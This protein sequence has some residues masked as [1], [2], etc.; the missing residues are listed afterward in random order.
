M[1][2]CKCCIQPDT[3]PGIYFDKQGICGV[4]LNMD[5]KG[6]MPMELSEIPLL[7]AR[8]KPFGWH[9][10]Y[11]FPGKDLV[12]LETIFLSIETVIKQYNSGKHFSVPSEYLIDDVSQ[13]V[14]NLIIGTAR[15]SNYWDLISKR[16]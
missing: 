5:N 16:E 3:R 13:R 10:E 1:K 15:L 2:V 14:L 12:D 4:R 11:L 7:E 8:I 9:I 6:G